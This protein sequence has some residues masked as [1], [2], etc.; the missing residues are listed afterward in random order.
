MRIPVLMVVGSNDA[1]RDLSLGVSMDVPSEGL[2]SG[3]ELDTDFAPVPLTVSDGDSPT[4]D[5]TTAESASSYVVRGFVDADPE[6]PPTE[7]DGVTVYADPKVEPLLTCGG[8]APVGTSADVA[9]L[10]DVANLRGRGLDG[11]NVAI[12]IVDTGINL[13]H[14]K[15]KLG[16]TPA[17]DSANSW[18]PKGSTTAAGNYPVGHGT[19]CAF[20]VLIAAPKATLIDIPVLQAGGG[21]GSVMSGYLSAALLAFSNVLVSWSVAGTGSGL[22]QYAAVVLSNSW[23]IF[24][25]S[26]DFPSGHPGRYCDNPRHPF[27]MILEPMARA[28]VDVVFAA[29]NCGAD[30][31][32]VR[33]KNRTAECIMG[34]SASVDAFSI[35]GCDIH[36][37][38]VGYSSQGPSI[39]GMY[40][41]KPDITGYTHF[42]GS[43]YKPGKPDS[44][45]SAACPVVAGCIAAIRTKADPRSPVTPYMLYDHFRLNATLPAGQGSG[46]NADYGHGIV[47]PVAVADQLG[48]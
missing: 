5:V 4:A 42:L 29:G 15:K 20:D 31:P 17:L 16:S 32:D 36:G 33:C 9:K 28:G 45:T 12:G 34:A 1:I 8:T 13:A 27:N 30:C 3:L 21:G 39:T 47:N 10:L 23:G 37:D 22:D 11:S 43:Q 44:G 26:M 35:A 24:H 25:P 19:M 40:G 38:R 48:F 14:L 6:D 7:L 2:P 41:Q 18:T 46:W